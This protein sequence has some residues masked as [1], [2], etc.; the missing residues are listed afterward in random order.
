MK[1]SFL[2]EEQSTSAVRTKQSYLPLAPR[3]QSM[4]N[5]LQSQA[6]SALQAS[7]DIFSTSLPHH[8]P[9]TQDSMTERIHHLQSLRKSL[10]TIL[11]REVLIGCCGQTSKFSV[12]GFPSKLIKFYLTARELIPEI[13]FTEFEKYH[14]ERI[15]RDKKTKHTWSTTIWFDWCP[16]KG[17]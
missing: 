6:L 2:E 7:R 8:L 1:L 15:Y 11:E 13:D 3:S 14:R 17:S 9:P 10:P 12:T 5:T 16:P 4:D